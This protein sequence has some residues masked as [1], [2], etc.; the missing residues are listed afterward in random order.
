M[1]GNSRTGSVAP[2]SGS[3]GQPLDVLFDLLSNRRRRYALAHLADRER[4]TA[5]ADLARAVAARENGVPTAEVTDEAVQRTRTSLHH[6]HLPKLADAGA[7]E[8]DRDRNR[9]RASAAAGT[10][11]RVRSLAADGGPEQ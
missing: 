4:P 6:A 8:F 9:V 3:N 11:E 5:L 1:V 2:R 7:V 10:L